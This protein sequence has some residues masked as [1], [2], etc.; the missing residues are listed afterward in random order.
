MDIP[1]EDF[2]EDIIG[3]AMRGTGTSIRGL[4]ELSG[5]TPTGIDR[6]LGGHFDEADARSVA[7][8]LGL[9]PDALAASGR[10][11][12]RPRP[13]EVEGLAIFNTPWRDMRVNAFVVWEPA[14]KSAAAFDTGA[15]AGGMIEFVES[16]GLHI[17]AVYIT[18]THGDH[19]ADLER[20]RDAFGDP[21]VFV[22]DREPVDGANLID[23][24][25]RSQIGGLRLE[26]RLTWGHSVG[27]L[28][29][30]VYGLARPVAVVG[31]AMFAGS[32][33]GGVVS[34]PD[35]LATNRSEILSLPDDCVICPGHGPMTSVG[36]EKAHNPFFAGG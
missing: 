19:I 15:D 18:H 9:D 31:D 32:M 11:S 34:Y 36:E 21:P 8:H 28:T 2:C 7:P 35:A 24:S 12:W 23:A 10:G 4:A 6:L 29:Y 33:G 1:I 27:G 26:A 22:G 25:H 3:K 20:V 13:V 30:V 14:S 16:E 5:V 17:G